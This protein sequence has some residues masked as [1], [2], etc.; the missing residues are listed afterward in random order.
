[1][2]KIVDLSH[3]LE[4]NMIVYPEDDEPRFETVAIADKDGYNSTKITMNYHLGTHIDV[5]YHM[6]SDGLTVDRLPVDLFCGC[7]IIIDVSHLAGKN[8][9]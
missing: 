4:A 3:L 2:M 1:M 6:M 8:F 5:P 7:A 9:D